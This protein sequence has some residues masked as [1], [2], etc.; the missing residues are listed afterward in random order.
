MANTIWDIQGSGSLNIIRP[1]VDQILV[2]GCSVRMTLV[3]SRLST[4][5]PKTPFLTRTTKNTPALNLLWLHSWVISPGVNEISVDSQL[6][7]LTQKIVSPKYS[8]VEDIIR[9]IK[10]QNVPSWSTSTY[11]R[12]G[13]TDRQTGCLLYVSELSMGGSHIREPTVRWD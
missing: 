8:C 6:G 2:N 7:H 4:F 10:F 1:I 13:Q 11:G 5:W 3:K 9:N 12:D